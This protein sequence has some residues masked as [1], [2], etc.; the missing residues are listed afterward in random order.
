MIMAFTSLSVTAF[1]DDSRD[2]E[3]TW[4]FVRSNNGESVAL[5]NS[6]GWV[7][8]SNG[9]YGAIY[10]D[11]TT[12]YSASTAKFT[13][14]SNTSWCQINKGTILY[15]P[16]AVGSAITI[17]TYYS[18]PTFTINDST[19]LTGSN[20]VASYEV[21]SSDLTTLT[22]TDDVDYTYVKVECTSN[23]YIST[24]KEDNSNATEYSDS[25]SFTWWFDDHATNSDGTVPA[26]TYYA[27]GNAVS[28]D[29]TA[30]I[31]LVPGLDSDGTTTYDYYTKNSSY[32]VTYNGTT[33][34]GYRSQNRPASANSLTS[35][36]SAGSS[37][38]FTPAI[39][40]TATI[41]NGVNGSNYYNI[42]DFTDSS[43]LSAHWTSTAGSSTYT[44]SAETGHTYLVCSTTSTNNLFFCGLKYLVDDIQTVILTLSGTDDISE[45][46]LSALEIYFTDVDTGTVY[47]TATSSDTE[48]TLNSGHTYEIS[49][50]D[51]SVA[52]SLT[53]SGDTEF[54]FS[55]S[56]VALTLESVNDVT[57]TGSITS[58]SSDNAA[59]VVSSITFTKMSDSTTAYTYDSTYIDT[60]AGTY[61]VSIKPGEYNT[62]VV[63]TDGSTTSDRVSVASS[64]TTTNE[65]YLESSED[66]TYTLYTDLGSL[67]SSGFNTHSETYGVYGGVGATIIVPVTANQKV[68]ATGSYS[69]EFTISGDSGD[70]TTVTSSGDAS[71]FSATYTTADNDSYVT[72]T[73]TTVG[74]YSGGSA[75]YIKTIEVETITNVAF[76]NSISVGE[77]GDY[78]TVTE[79]ITAIKNMTDRP[80]GESGRVTITLTDDVQEQVLVDADYVTI[81]GAG[82]EI[83]WY[84]GLIC[85]YYSVDS[86][87]YY[88]ESL[89]RDK[90]EKT[91]TN[92]SLWGGVVIVK[93][94]YFKAENVT[95][96]NTFNYEV[97]EKELLDGVEK[98]SN[99]CTI[100]Y[101]E[102]T[103]KGIGVADLYSQKERAN[104]L[105]LQ[106][107]HAE[108]NS[109][110]ILSSQDTLGYNGS[111]DNYAYFKDCTIGGNVDYICGAGT[112]VFDDCTLQFYV[113]SGQTELGYITAP[114]TNPYIFRNCKITTS[115]GSTSYTGYYGRTWGTGSTAY[116]IGC[117]TNGH[118]R[119]D[120]WGEMSKTQLS[121]AL[122]YE[123]GNTSGGT[124][125]STSG[126]Y[127]GKDSDGNSITVNLE[128]S[129][130]SSDS[131]LANVI[132]DDVITNCL[133]SWTPDYYTSK[134]ASNVF[135]Y[136]TEISDS[137]KLLVY[138][139]LPSTYTD[140]VA[141]VGIYFT[142]ASDK[143]NFS[144]SFNDDAA[145]T[146]E[147]VYSSITFG[148]NESSYTDE[149]G[150][151]VYGAV[152][153]D[154]TT[155][156]GTIY[157]YT[158]ITTTGGTTLYS[159]GT[160]LGNYYS[161]S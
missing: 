126:A 145:D 81:N 116:F 158:Y 55:G 30:T 61:T 161:N 9:A 125:F 147:V 113:Q 134:F 133:G 67:T 39:D 21:T 140:D 14:A 142:T 92:T 72:I 93:G 106:G 138:G 75:C 80:E 38:Y 112:M 19:S 118:I 101:Q 119:T 74:N 31:T 151:Y 57:L 111:K 47:A 50:N 18:S 52:A 103:T 4:N 32:S 117:E 44:F 37:Y 104:A 96:K 114:K 100:T 102:R 144:S 78:S 88:S 71:G 157:A 62:S 159:T 73:V 35:I 150:G 40:G 23:D 41:Y 20:Y 137:G 135:N 69:G 65:I 154:I 49:T 124:A 128:T 56:A 68:T 132:N 121:S 95:F 136:Y 143:T 139:N 123:Y 148:T 141:E 11:T 122:F 5:E 77:S 146:S 13:N 43:T 12:N 60:S 54:T 53:S 51:S 152:I 64:G 70:G 94:D 58:A 130:S 3:Y 16:A 6:N 156:S 33:Y 107:N 108:F 129:L 59:S 105:S 153:S 155:Y 42:Y 45:S 7:Y 83:N 34:Y 84:Y 2:D 46:S 90:Y 48:V 115:D 85:K 66:V 131:K 10:V 26:G 82:N 120:G 22:Y 36:P 63:T 86:D 98:G 1:A 110:S 29:C 149:N 160:A 15:L 127:S 99:D 89:F 87:G 79:A 25:G 97:T 27:G 91:D 109:C 76:T 17:N 24:I 28:G 8:T